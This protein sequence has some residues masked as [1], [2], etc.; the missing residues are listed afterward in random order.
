ML[1]ANVIDTSVQKSFLTGMPGVFEHVYSLS[2]IL[3]D[4]VANKKPLMTNFLD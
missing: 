1:K 2:A 3:Q 4:C